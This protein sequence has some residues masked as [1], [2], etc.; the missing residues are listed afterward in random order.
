M[1][2]SDATW[3]TQTSESSWVYSQA[4]NA[5]SSSSF[6]SSFMLAFFF[7]MQRIKLIPH[8]RQTADLNADHPHHVWGKTCALSGGNNVTALIP[9]VQKELRIIMGASSLPSKRLTA[10]PVHANLLVSH[11]TLYKQMGMKAMLCD[12]C[13]TVRTWLPHWF[14]Y[15]KYVHLRRVHRVAYTCCCEPAIKMAPGCTQLPGCITIAC[16]P[17]VWSMVSQGQLGH[18]PIWFCT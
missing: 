4:S 3:E 9:G 18:K 7:L 5:Q 1:Y 14:Q 13:G 8:R 6:F 12:C 10:T 16:N 17:K 2:K 11:T 15:Y